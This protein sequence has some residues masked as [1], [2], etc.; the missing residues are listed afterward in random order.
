[1]A[2]EKITFRP[3]FPPVSIDVM[4]V[5]KMGCHWHDA[6]EIVWVL[7]G[8]VALKE[9]NLLLH[10]KPGDIYVVNYNETHK[11]SAQREPAVIVSARVDYRY[12]T[13]YIPNLNEISFAHYCFS[14][15]VD[16]E[17]ALKNCH[18]FIAEL[19]PLLRRETPGKE[20]NRKIE[21]LVH[22]L[23]LLI[24]D[25]F[26][27]I[28]Y[29]KHEDRYRDAIDKSI[30]L[31]QE[32]LK[33]LHRLTHYIY[34]NCHDK[35]TLDDVAGTEYYSK[36]HISH[37]IKK[38]YG[39]SYQETLCLSRV[40]ISERVLLETDYNMD[41]VAAVT[42]FST[43]NQ[44]CQQFKKWHGVT[45]S[46]FRK[47]NGPGGPGGV[48]LLFDCDEARARALLG[49]DPLPVVQKTREAENSDQRYR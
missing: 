48:D 32:Q 49:L 18:R 12:F 13:K 9:S 31:S 36:F 34:T 27:Y 35:L 26:Q 42:G 43:R 28:Y 40:A 41:R 1:M 11:I 22:S 8:E 25:T 39:L 30:N 4:Q 45:P 17:E 3:G 5:S 37:F 23:L 7:S 14:K 15:N 44:Y 10:L 6:L 47:E 2:R 16:V 46:Q 29:H 33:R 24:I 21:S 38:A 19:Y 20:E